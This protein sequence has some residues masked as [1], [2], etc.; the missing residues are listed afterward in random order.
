MS[1]VGE[2]P[3]DSSRA[4][5]RGTVTCDH[6]GSMGFAV[7]VVPSHPSLADWSDLGLIAWAT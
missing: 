3:N 5:Y 2:D 4:L 6:P 7:R 1:H